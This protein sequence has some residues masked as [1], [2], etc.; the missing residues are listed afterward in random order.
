M[1]NDE[2]IVEADVVIRLTDD[3]FSKIKPLKNKQKAF[4]SGMILG[5][6]GVDGNGDTIA[7]SYIPHE[8]AVKIRDLAYQELSGGQNDASS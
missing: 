7:L 3:Q 1:S 6:V 4:N 2:K 8:L 5:S